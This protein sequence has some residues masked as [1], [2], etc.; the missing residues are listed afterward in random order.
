MLSN[1]IILLSISTVLAAIPVIIWLY[2][3]F[4]KTKE[5]KKTLLVVFGLGCL[6]APALLGVQYLWN[7][8]PRFNLSAFIEDTIQTQSTMYIATFVLFGAMEEIIKHYVIS[9]VDKKTAL[10][11]TIG[12]TIRY[13]LVAALG[14]AFTEN[15]YYL[16][17]F[18][19]SISMGE[20]AG[21]YA[22]RSIFTACAHMIFSGIFGYYYA[23][24]KFSIPIT[25][26]EKL[27]G[28]HERFA[29]L[30]GKLFNMPLSHA[31]QQKIVLKGL[32]LAVIIHA[33]FNFVLQ[34]NI[35]LPV[36]IFVIFGFIFLQYLLRRKIDYL[37]IEK[38]ITEKQKSAM[39]KKDEDVI[40]ELI[41]MWFKDKRYTDVVHICER[42]LEKD[43][44]NSL[45][46]LFKAK[47]LDLLENKDTY[48]SV[49]NS[50]ITT[51]GE[52]ND[53]QRNILTKYLEEKEVLKQVKEMVKKQLKKEGKE[54][55]EEEKP[56][57]SQ[58]QKTSK[59]ILEDYT[60]EGTFKM[61]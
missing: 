36:I 8:F 49:L 43:P 41:G 51:K 42:L 19:P 24:G 40:I 28:K 25:K 31:F 1:P 32:F 12:A 47:S 45:V 60:G 26:E 27:I 29:G 20:L 3:L 2:I 13:S 17:Q 52:F 9:A 54:F 14:F 50:A 46:Q 58:P 21:M 10:I 23:M 57:I 39:A 30:I 44:D 59:T 34:F 22:F 61:E 38:D 7:I 16:Y 48:R 35:I 6:T 18:W 5:S 4:K 55:K 11:N 56:K 33:T 37:I 53:K 15:I